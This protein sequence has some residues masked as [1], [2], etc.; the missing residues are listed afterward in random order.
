ML[1]SMKIHI[2][3]GMFSSTSYNNRGKNSMELIPKSDLQSCLLSFSWINGRFSN[4]HCCIA[5]REV[6]PEHTSFSWYTLHSMAQISLLRWNLFQGSVIRGGLNVTIV[7][8]FFCC[9]FFN[10]LV[11]SMAA[12][13]K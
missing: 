5:V 12:D 8:H 9:C 13:T 3:N 4:I 6:S 11:S 7:R 10:I 2:K 1:L